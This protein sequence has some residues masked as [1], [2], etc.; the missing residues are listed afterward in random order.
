MKW[1]ILALAAWLCLAQDIVPP[2]MLA[3][4]PLDPDKAPVGT[5][6][7]VTAAFATEEGHMWALKSNFKTRG[8]YCASNGDA[9]KWPGGW[10]IVL[11]SPIETNGTDSQAAKGASVEFAFVSISSRR[12]W[13]GRRR[14]GC[15]KNIARAVVDPGVGGQ[16]PYTVSLRAGLVSTC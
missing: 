15:S 6:A 14:A 16:V 12:R 8:I 3:S 13:A 10:E 2:D 4:R 1:T 9:R 11:S 5:K 7:C